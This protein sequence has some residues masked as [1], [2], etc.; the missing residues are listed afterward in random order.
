LCFQF[1]GTRT[2]LRPFRNTFSVVNFEDFR[3]STVDFRLSS[4]ISFYNPA[5]H[6]RYLE[7]V[8]CAFIFV[9]DALFFYL[10]TKTMHIKSRIRTALLCFPLKLYTPARFE[11]GSSVSEEEGMPTAP[12]R[13]GRLC[14]HLCWQGI[15]KATNE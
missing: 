2:L 4:A 10:N 6:H 1:P 5:C 12:R 3:L 15:Q 7:N 13:Q 9:A 8:D 11:P 14:M